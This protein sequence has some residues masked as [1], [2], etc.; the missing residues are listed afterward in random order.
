MVRAMKLKDCMFYDEVMEIYLKQLDG[1][2]NVVDVDL[3]AETDV[4]AVERSEEEPPFFADEEGNKIVFGEKTVRY[5]IVFKN[6]PCIVV[7]LKKKIRR[8]G[9]VDYKGYIDH[10]CECECE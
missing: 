6:V 9:R 5:E 10:I 4:L 3:S 7:V 8:D 2:E 1:K